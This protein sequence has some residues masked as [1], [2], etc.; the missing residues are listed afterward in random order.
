MLDKW[1]AL[2][3]RLVVS[4]HRAI[5]AVTVLLTVLSCVSLSRLQ[6][7]PAPESLLASA[8][9]DLHAVEE[10][11]SQRYGSTGDVIVALVSQQEGVLTREVLGYLYELTEFAA[12]LPGVRRV[13][14]LTR[15]PFRREQS[16][17]QASADLTLDN[18]DTQK[19]DPLADD[20]ALLSALSDVVAAAP[21]HFPL[22]LV[23]LSERMGNVTYGPLIQSQHPSESDV[24]A[25]THALRDAPLLTGRLIGKSQRDALVAITLEPAKD[26]PESSARVTA[27]RRALERFV[28]EQP[29]PRDAE[30][31]L[32]GLPV[33][34][35]T[36]M[37]HMQRD[38]IVLVPATLAVSLL[39]MLA[40]LRWWAGVLLPLVQVGV[41]SLA[42][43]GGMA[44]FGIKLTVITNTL[45]VLLIIL[46]LS[47]SIHLVHRY[48]EELEH[49]SDRALALQHAV[50]AVG[51][52]C[53]G[54]ASTTAA[55]M[56]ALA[57]CQTRM[58]A[59]FGLV[60]GFG[61]LLA[62]AS[63]LLVLPALL[64][65]K[66]P[67]APAR[68]AHKRAE[69]RLTR[70]LVI[71][72]I[73]FVKRPWAT[74]TLA[75]LLSAA[76]YVVGTGV[77]IDSAVLDQ[78][79]RSDEVY[80]T[81]SLLEREFEGVRTLEVSL[82]AGKQGRFFDPK[83]LTAIDSVARWARTQKGV[84]STLTPADPLQQAWAQL[85]GE[86]SA[87]DALRTTEEV[88]GLA[89]IVD[90]RDAQL[91]MLLANDGR[92]ARVRIKL[93]DIGSRATLKFADALRAELAKQLA[94]A[95]DVKATLLGDAYTNSRGLTAVVTD[96]TGSLTAAL[97]TVLVLVVI[98]F[99]SFRYGLLTLPPGAVPLLLTLGWMAAR[100]IPLN[101]ATA[102]IFSISIGIT[103]DGSI[104]VLARLREELARTELFHTALLRTVRGT[105]EALLVACGALLAGFSVL[106]LSNFVPVQRFA[107]LIAVS[108]GSCILTTLVMLPALLKLVGRR[109]LSG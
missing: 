22:G 26:G 65:G 10:A 11:F 13:D 88:K 62:Y 8:N 45:P 17:E 27:T 73:A 29:R 25:L 85:G 15:T 84:L 16:A 87:R 67:S 6:R 86:A 32:G 108:I 103:V 75:V 101:A 20:P 38:Q 56:F 40:S 77:R 109:F 98:S 37:E 79:R 31:R 80:E 35:N 44:L 66:A 90:K 89:N 72:T 81:T 41:T 46:G 34:N 71:W 91:G 68:S 4:R 50:S 70:W 100:D 57:F 9:G 14:S 74:V 12:K 19:D 39:I 92:Y 59:E 2:C 48:V 78:F 60:A 105:G 47:D 99:R 43:L 76:A 94:I 61:V 24:Q 58:L 55:G 18:L 3:S 42:V 97:L 82:E 36:I 96:L 63:T 51:R 1:L 49:T 33:V 107:E 30:V 64:R 104:H 5:I 23:T 7:D 28:A 102:I 106:L 95:P 93:A 21:E 54:T 53:F 83:V 52:A 69:S